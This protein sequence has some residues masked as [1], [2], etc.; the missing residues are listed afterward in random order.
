MK[1]ADLRNP[2]SALERAFRILLRF[3]AAVGLFFLAACSKQ[4]EWDEE[5]LLNTGEILWVHRT[6]TFERKSEPGNPLQAAW[7]PESRRYEFARKDH[8]YEYAVP[9]GQSPG[10]MAIAIDR[11][12]E[13]LIIDWQKNCKKPGYAVLRW[14]GGDWRIQP[15]PPE[16]FYGTRRNLLGWRSPDGDI[17]KRLTSAM[18]Q[19][20][21]QQHGGQ[22]RPDEIYSLTA[23]NGCT[24]KSN[25]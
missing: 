12:G 6:D 4:V 15:T 5:V 3:A 10:P 2:S 1:S 23:A 22:R 18:K 25:V 7:W 17:P 13:V 21:D 14:A 9:S 24:K 20:L 19:G 8:R 11:D 16:P